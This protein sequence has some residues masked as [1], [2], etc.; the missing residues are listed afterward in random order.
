V[1][2][3]ATRRTSAGSPEFRPI[4]SLRGVGTALAARFA[5]LGVNTV[6]DLLFLL[7]LRYEDR[8]RII[9]IGSLRIGDRA[10][11][12]GEILL[13]EVAFR[14]RRQLLCRLGDGTGALTLRFFHFS[15]A[16]QQGFQ[17][18]TRWRCWG[19]VRRGP[20]GPEI[21]HPEYR[22]IA[23]AGTHGMEAST[24]EGLTP[25]YPLTEGIQQG[26]LRQLTLLA[27]QELSTR[28]LPDWLPA[29]LLESL[30]LQLPSLPDAL[31]YVH[32]PPIDADT[33]R[34][35][36]GRHPAQR[37][38]AFEELLAHQLSLRLL[39]RE[40]QRD[41][42]WPLAPARPSLI[43]QLRRSL[44]FVP[45]DAQLRAWSDIEADLA[46]S[47][48]MLRL[49][50][51]DVDCGKTLVAAFAAARAVEAGFQA[52]IMAPTELLAEQ[53]ARNFT[54]WFAPL[55]L[56]PVLLTGT[57]STAA[58][59]RALA[60]LASGATKLAVGTHALFQHDVEFHRLGLVIIDE[61]HRFGVHQRLLLREKGL[62]SGRYPHQLIM[63][64]TPIPRTLAMT[65]YADLD[66]SVID[67]LPPGRTP[68]RTVVLHENRRD[69]VVV[70]IRDACR[71]QRQAYWVCPLVEESELLNAQ[72]A[73]QTAAVLAEAL[74]ELNVGLVHGR[75][76][77]REKEAVMSRFK[78]GEIDLLV[79]TT[80]IEVGVDVPNASLMVIENAERM[81]LAQLH[82][83]RGRVGRGSAESTCVL[84]YRAPLSEIARERLAVLRATNDGF[85]ISRRDLELRGPGELLGTRQTGLMQMRVADLMRDAD[86]LPMVQQAAERMLAQG[87]ET[88]APLLRRWTGQGERFGKV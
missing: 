36:A 3:A 81:G 61:Q 85:E 35:A 13:A 27:L 45:T 26:R 33:E 7:P 76:P 43:E 73:E 28:T 62:A 34:L 19:E 72:A 56:P 87:E 10:V 25:V 32:R 2:A 79:A 39:R 41:P 9:P 52:V 78:A 38:L 82:Q 55:E 40:I 63:T 30:G 42:G 75:M 77:P 29:G 48:P 44:P 11:V 20:A 88:V 70:R 5:R 80:V 50:Q 74:Q 12:E 4:V 66:V 46:R 86:L 18:G 21:V 47:N 49:V 69:E 8:T 17:R 83:L 16:Q 14:G 1:S 59:T 84:L 23:D 71:Q 31:R 53:H 54:T 58:R 22:R 64:A 6:Q 51:G 67:E 37:R 57:R 68:V 15:L 24:P 60:D 65:A